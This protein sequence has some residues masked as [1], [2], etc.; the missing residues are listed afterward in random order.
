MEIS[1]CL[2]GV[3]FIGGEVIVRNEITETQ[4]KSAISQGE[5]GEDIRLAA[6]RVAVVLTQ[7][8]CPQ[9]SDL[10]R[11]LSSLEKDPALDGAKPQVFELVYNKV[12]YSAEFM[13]FKENT[14]NN[15][16]I[17]YVRYYKNGELVDESNW[18]S[19]KGFLARLGIE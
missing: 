8:W 1:G 17:P 16:E 18:V 2:F 3:L 10:K 9:W 19:K 12:A 7:G 15:Y 11:T 5:F 14:F 6:D 13:A 4:A